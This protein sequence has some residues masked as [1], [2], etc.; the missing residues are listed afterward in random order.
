MESCSNQ[1]GVKQ[2]NIYLYFK[3]FKVATL[4]LDDGF[5]HSWNSLNQLHLEC[6]SNR[7]EEAPS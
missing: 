6:F 7:L 4:C 3:F 2:M 1:K 5:A